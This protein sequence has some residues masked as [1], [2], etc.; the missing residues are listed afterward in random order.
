M[1]YKGRAKVLFHPRVV[2]LV[3]N[4]AHRRKILTLGLCTVL[5]INLDHPF[6][7]G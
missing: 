4:T 6:P 3:L 5:G 7:L 1:D 2:L